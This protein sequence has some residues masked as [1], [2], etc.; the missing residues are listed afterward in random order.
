MVAARWRCFS[1]VGRR[2][3]IQAFDVVWLAVVFCLL[4]VCLFFCLL[5]VDCLFYLL[6]SFSL[7]VFAALCE[8]VLSCSRYCSFVVCS[9]LVYSIADDG[10]YSLITPIG[11]VQLEIQ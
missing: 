9:S 10:F 7:F 5:L 8:F 3:R 1:R 11:L 6:L 2:P 4:V